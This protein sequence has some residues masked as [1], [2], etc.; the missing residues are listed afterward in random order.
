MSLFVS[1]NMITLRVPAGICCDVV[2]S[3]GLSGYFVSGVMP[4]N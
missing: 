2:D 4:I 3:S 1:G